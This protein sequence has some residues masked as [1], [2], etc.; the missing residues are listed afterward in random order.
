[1][2]TILNW[3]LG[4]SAEEPALLSDEARGILAAVELLEPRPT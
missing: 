3:M 2:R 1:M 4:P